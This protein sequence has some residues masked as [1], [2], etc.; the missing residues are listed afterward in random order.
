MNS[1]ARERACR[2]ACY[3]APEHTRMAK[4]RKRRLRYDDERTLDRD[5]AALK[6][7]LSGIPR[8]DATRRVAALRSLL[9]AT[10][11]NAWALAEL[12]AA[13]AERREDA[14]ADATLRRS[15]TLHP[16]QVPARAALVRLLRRRGEHDR[17]VREARAFV[18]LLPDSPEAQAALGLALAAQGHAD[19]ARPYLSFAEAAHAWGGGPDRDDEDELRALQDAR[20]DARAPSLS[21]LQRW[22]GTEQ[23]LVELVGSCFPD[24]A[25]T[26]ADVRSLER[27]RMLSHR[28]GAPYRYRDA[29]ELALGLRLRR[30]GWG[31]ESIALTLENASDELLRDLLQRSSDRAPLPELGYLDPSAPDYPAPI[32][33]VSARRKQR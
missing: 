21:E 25:P 9:T 6:K 12:G 16:R 10:P 27:G 22:V 1:N 31:Y 5:L 4:H 14:E 13:L 7:A 18:R 17:A 30:H 24:P 20:F 2:R 11:E 8:D 15:L 23:E 28:P 33:P 32:E 29:L 3:P 19:K 26:L